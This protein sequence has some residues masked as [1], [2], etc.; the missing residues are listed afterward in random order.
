M[1]KLKL[2]LACLSILFAA[3]AQTD[4]N[5]PVQVKIANGIIEG[6]YNTKDGLQE[7]FSVPVNNQ[8]YRCWLDGILLKCRVWRLC[9]ACLYG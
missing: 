8:K 4:Y 9:R 5:L 2:L 6:N 1:K 7:F 3:A